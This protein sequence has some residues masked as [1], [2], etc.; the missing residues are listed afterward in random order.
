VC[1]LRDLYAVDATKPYAEIREFNQH[2]YA[3]TAALDGNTFVVEGIHA[4]AG[5]KQ[6]T[7][8]AFDGLTGNELWCIPTQSTR[9]GSFLSVD[10]QSELLLADRGDGLGVLIELRTKKL[11]ASQRTCAH[12][13]PGARYVGN[14]AAL[15]R[16]DDGQ[17]VIR[18][19]TVVPSACFQPQFSPDGR[20]FAW[21]N[22]EGSVFVCDISEV[23][24]RL[25]TVGLAN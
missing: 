6:R 1:R 8:R 5:E 22:S 20:Y 18:F 4:A 3:T 11:I 24:R 14:S 2:V 9:D 7:L 15:R 10:P 16:G 25:S 23:V 17:E 13:S 21:G 19:P 12:L